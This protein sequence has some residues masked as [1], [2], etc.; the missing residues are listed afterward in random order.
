MMRVCRK[1]NKFSNCR[2]KKIPPAKNE[3]E[4]KKLFI[5]RKLKKIEYKRI[6]NYEKFITNQKK[7]MVNRVVKDGKGKINDT[8]ANRKAWELRNNF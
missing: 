4:I 2:S 3:N 1:T 7:V 6:E 8:E 5:A